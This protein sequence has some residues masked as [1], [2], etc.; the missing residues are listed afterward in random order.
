[1]TGSV[2]FTY[3]RMNPP[4]VGHERLVET[5][6]NMFWVHDRFLFLSPSNDKNKN[7]LSF[8]YKHNLCKKAFSK[9]NLIISQ[10]PKKDFF[11]AIISIYS[12]GYSEVDIIVGSDR[13]K[14][15][16]TRIP[17]YNGEL[18]KFNRIDIHQVNRGNN[19]DLASM[20]SSTKMREAA[21]SDDFS[22]F[23]KGLPK[24]LKPVA[25]DIYEEVRR[26]MLKGLQST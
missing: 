18:Y 10:E 16:S 24:K 2:A 14:E 8:E 20:I 21:V 7:P 15:L 23:V 19:S 17:K 6:S 22:Y 11:D 13:Y 9:H 4:T 25:R 5:L 1:M 3:C 26:C 12:H